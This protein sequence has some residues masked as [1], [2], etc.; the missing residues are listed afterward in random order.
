M[1][2]AKPYAPYT[3]QLRRAPSTRLG[4]GAER[5]M[6]VAGLYEGVDLGRDSAPVG[7]ITYMRTVSTRVAPGG[8]SASLRRLHRDKYGRARSEGSN[9]C[10][11]KGAQSA[12]KRIA[13]PHALTTPGGGAQTPQDKQFKAL[14]A[15]L[16]SL[17]RE[18]R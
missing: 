16:G 2:L 17:R 6:R 12:T 18:T 1:G 9:V 11:S 15:D 5:A 7:L 4:F 3:E 14:Q 10:W 13:R 8:Y